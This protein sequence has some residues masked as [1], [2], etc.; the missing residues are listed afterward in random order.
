ML[1][2][3]AGMVVPEIAP[4]DVD[5]AMAGGVPIHAEAFTDSAGYTGGKGTGVILIWRPLADVWATLTRYDDRVEYIPRV[6]KLKVLG[7]QGN[8]VHVWQEIDA[9]VTTARFTA[10]YEL[11]EKAHVIHWKLDPAAG[12]NTLRDVDGDYTLVAV[13]ANRTLLSYQSTIDT[14][15]HVPRAIQ[16][17]MT[18]KSLP[19]L[20]GNIKKRVESGGKWKR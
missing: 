14:A 10:W 18:R 4:A 8:R 20:L 19:E 6:K 2:G 17:Y 15:F 12:D 13:D 16:A 11:D 3:L 5:A 1:L 7:Q 9:A